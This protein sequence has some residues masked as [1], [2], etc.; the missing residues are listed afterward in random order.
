DYGD[1]WALSLAGTPRW[2]Q[3]VT[4][5]E[6]PHSRFSHAAVFDPV[7]RRLVIFGGYSYAAGQLADTWAL[8]LAG[9][10]A[11]HQLAA[12]GRAPIH[13]E[14]MRAVYDPWNDRM[15]M[16]GGWVYGDITAYPPPYYISDETWT[17]P[18]ANPAAWDSL[19][20][21]ARP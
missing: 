18:L 4:T 13:R 21:P 20:L 10:P 9:T 3:I 19:A 15:V 8:E 12:S 6:A 17:L 14:G 11:W 7:R 16:F 2:T 1:S 5:G